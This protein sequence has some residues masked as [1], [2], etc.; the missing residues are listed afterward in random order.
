MDRF[1]DFYKAEW[2]HLA[3]IIIFESIK[4]VKA[5]RQA[6]GFFIIGITR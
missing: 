4:N 5:Y 6:A 2:L 3:K 1:G